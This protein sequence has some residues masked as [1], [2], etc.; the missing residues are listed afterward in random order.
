VSLVER[1]GIVA[2]LPHV[3]AGVIDCI[4]IGGKPPMYVLQATR[5]SV[6]PVW[7]GNEMNVIRHQAKADQS[8]PVSLDA[9]LQQGEIDAALSITF[10]DEAPRIASLRYVMGST[11]SNHTSESNHSFTL[12]YL[13]P[14]ASRCRVC[15]PLFGSSAVHPP[16]SKRRE[17]I[18]RCIDELFA[19]GMIKWL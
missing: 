12:T 3:A 11:W 14:S 15:R 4:P 18:M 8:Y 5:Q 16:Y 19:R 13:H 2:A 10:K 17:S 9:L 1:A 6:P 7:D